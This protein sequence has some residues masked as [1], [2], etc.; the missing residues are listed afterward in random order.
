MNAETLRKSLSAIKYPESGQDLVKLG[1]VRQLDL[2]GPDVSLRL[3]T[4]APDRKVQIA[5]ETQIRTQVKKDHPEIGKLKIKFEVDPSLAAQL[6]Q[7]LPHVKNI[8]AVGSGKGGVGKSTVTVNLAGALQQLGYKVGILDADI[9]GPSVPKMLGFQGKTQLQTRDG[10]T[11]IPA[12]YKGL[13]VI[14][15]GFLLDDDQPVV[16]RGPMLGKALEQFLFEIEWGELDFLLLDLP[17]GTGDTQLSLAQLVELT[18][19]LIVSTPQTV[20]TLDASRAASM[21]GQLKVPLLG[22][23][24]NMGAFTCPH[25]GE[26]SEIFSTGGGEVFAR[27]TGAGFLGSIPLHQDIMKNAES[28][29]VATLEAKPDKAPAH[30]KPYFEIAQKLVENRTFLNL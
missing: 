1:L 10:N 22:V 3:A 26:T 11:I 28:G 5:L 25:C 15:F 29:T 18:G 21:F 23:I 6:D 9:Y 19:A 27:Q 14:S 4:P 13:K 24:E 12:E 30:L 20:A 8:I 17:P 16:W 7:K 2:D